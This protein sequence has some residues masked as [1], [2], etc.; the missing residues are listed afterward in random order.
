MSD[1]SF[2]PPMPTDPS[3]G[4]GWDAPGSGAGHGDSQPQFV[5]DE[6]G[7]PMMGPD[8]SPLIVIGEYGQPGGAGAVEVTDGTGMWLRS[9]D[10]QLIDEGHGGAQAGAQ[11]GG[12]FGEQGANPFAPTP[13]AFDGNPFAP[14]PGAFDGNP[15]P[16]T[17]GALDTQHPFDSPPPFELPGMPN[18]PNIPNMHGGDPFAA[19]TPN[20]APG[21]SFLPHS[22]PQNPFESAPFDPTHPASP[23]DPTHE[24]SPFDPSHQASPFDSTH[25][26]DPN[27]QGS[28]FDSSFDLNQHQG[29][30]LDNDPTMH[31]RPDHDSRGWF[32]Q[33]LPYDCGA[34]SVTQVLTEL[35]G[36]NSHSEKEVVDAATQMNLWASNPG[37]TK[38]DGMGIDGIEKLL[39]H[40]NVPSHVEQATDMH[41]L[42]DYLDK[43]FSVV[44]PVDA[45]PIW[46]GHEGQTPV[47]HAVLITGIDFERGVAVLSDTGTPGGNEETI[48]LEQL[49]EAWS[50][51]DFNMIV[52]E[53]PTDPEVATGQSTGGHIDTSLHPQHTND[54]FAPDPSHAAPPGAPGVPTTHPTSTGHPSLPTDIDWEKAGMIVMPFAFALSKVHERR[55]KAKAAA[56]EAPPTI[57]AAPA[58]VDATVPIPNPFS[59]TFSDTFSEAAV[60]ASPATAADDT[61]PGM[62]VATTL[63][64]RE[65]PG[66]LG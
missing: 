26:F 17:P 54:P 38:I 50:F 12:Q 31:G 65:L 20:E 10:G 32:T 61:V 59:D 28:P 25:A 7:A 35:F 40:F 58:P 39:D 24:A 29:R 18:V 33:S 1:H 4:M 53:H 56:A 34:A 16:P 62:H 15:F 23:F 22:G 3:H 37:S 45:N 55:T 41:Q 64:T 9:S 2:E 14:T 49:K 43:G 21:L 47:G 5:L 44:L 52:T 57:E 46:Y 30:G 51:S 11:F 27:H 13:G 8:G 36:P 48:S 42:A 19:P 63:T 60:G 66:F 6:S